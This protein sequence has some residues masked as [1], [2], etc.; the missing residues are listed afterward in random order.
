MQQTIFSSKYFDNKLKSFSLDI[1]KNLEHKQL[2][3]NRWISAIE[4]DNLKYSKETQLDITFLNDVFGKVLDYECG[5]NSEKLNLIPKQSIEDKEPDA[6]IGFF[7]RTNLAGFQNPQGLKLDIRAVIELKDTNTDLDRIQNRLEKISPVTQ[8]FEYARKAGENCKWVIVSNFKTIRLYN[9]ESDRYEIFELTDLRDLTYLKRFFY[10]LHKDRLIFTAGESHVDAL[11]RERLEEEQKITREFY[12]KFKEIRIKLLE[13]LILNN[14]SINKLILLEKTQ[15]ILDRVIFICFCSDLEILPTRLLNRIS[16]YYVNQEYIYDDNTLWYLIK[17]LFKTIDFG[18]LKISKLNGG[19]FAPD[20]ILDELL[21]NSEI[22]IEVFELAAYDYRSDLNVNILGHIFEQSISDL[23][24]LKKQIENPQGFKNL[25]GLEN[26]ANGKRKEFGVFYTPDYITN[27]IVK[28]TIGNW[29]ADARN[30]LGENELPILTEK[31]YDSIKITRQGTLKTNDK[32]EKNK[33]F[34]NDYLQKLLSI[35]VLDPA[36]GSGAFLVAAYDYLLKEYLLIQKELKILNPPEPH[37][38]NLPKIK[39]GFSFEV[40]QLYD[41]ENHIIKHNLYG[42][43]INF[44]SVEI[45]KLSLWLKTV[46]RGKILGDI[47]AN[48]QC[49]NSL[50]DYVSVVGMLAFDWNSR[51]ATIM[52]NGGFDIVIGNPPYINVELLENKSRKYLLEKYETCKGRTDIYIAFIEKAIEL[53]KHNGY[54]SF[55]IPYAFINQNYA[56]DLRKRLTENTSIKSIADL[57]NFYV[58]PDAMVK[59][60]IFCIQKSN[61]QVNTSIRFFNNLDDFFSNHIKHYSINQSNFLKLKENRFETKNIYPYLDIKEKIEYQSVTLDKICFIAYGAR[62]NQKESENGKDKYIF[63]HY[64]E[65]LKPFVEGKNIERYSFT[66]NAWLN[67][68]PTEHYNSMFPELFENEKIMLIRVVKDHIRFALDAENH[69][70]SHTVINCVRYDKIQNAQHISARNAIKEINIDYAKNINYKY[71]LALLNS[72]LMNWYFV[73]FLSDNI[74]FY[75]NEVK[76]LPIVYLSQNKQIPFIEIVDLMLSKKSEIQKN[77]NEFTDYFSVK[78][79]INNLSKNLSNWYQLTENQFLTELSK[80]KLNISIK[81][82][83]RILQFFKETKISA[84]ETTEEIER[85]DNEIDTMVYQLYN[86]TDNEINTIKLFTE[87]NS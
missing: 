17:Q 68:Q 19:L 7:E 41:I 22:L 73:T 85:I 31:D 40:K 43:D 84:I 29:L 1:F 52:E 35:K 12:A 48:I 23:E 82:E 39:G 34:W 10:L 5:I 79:N 74:N 9:K 37:E 6:V 2:I 36:C 66:R 28:E 33:K 47:D 38:N 57:S 75:P 62:L 58:F 18:N 81:E 53:L 78:Y 4:N 56:S 49:G 83:T 59:N 50:I 71:L 44:E 24:K 21:I 15:K 25:A 20:N 61:N 77:S 27:Y 51:F 42:V 86:L 67:Y 11:Y 32:I 8:A 87:T 45:T 26:A 69:Y 60:I 16:T 64:S 3:L 65:G 72:S 55:I 46:K 80:L 63:D 76:S 54:N 13:N 30:E 14:S 70:N